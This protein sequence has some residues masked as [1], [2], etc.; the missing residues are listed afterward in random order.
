MTVNW[1][2]KDKDWAFENLAGHVKKA[3]PDIQHVDNEPVGADVDICLSPHDFKTQE[4]DKKT[5]LHLDSHRWYE[6]FL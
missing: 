5:I 4:A 3:L 6:R 2:I 1:Q